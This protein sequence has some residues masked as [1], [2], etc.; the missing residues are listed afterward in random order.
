MHT[1]IDSLFQKN[2]DI[3]D[4]L[5][6]TE[7]LSFFTDVDVLFKKSLILSAASYFED[8]ITKILS[9]HAKKYSS[10]S[11]VPNFII[12]K[13]LK[14]QYHTFFNW[15]GSNANA[16]FSMFGDDFANQ[17]KKD[18]ENDAQLS[19]NI[20]SFI[21]IGKRRNELVHLNYAEYTIEETID[22]Y[23]DK[24]KEGLKFVYYITKKFE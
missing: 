11:L 2:K 19:V 4:Y 1:I 8:T 3:R 18:I 24:Y 5:M 17:C 13:A 14:R 23:Y 15:D 12:R 7:Q 6:E 20:K 22:Y 21:E 9:A 10:N 16:F